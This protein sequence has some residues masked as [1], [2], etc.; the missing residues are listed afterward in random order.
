MSDLDR[1]NSVMLAFSLL[2]LVLFH[3]GR[4]LSGAAAFVL[5]MS[6]KQMAIYYAPAV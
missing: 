6:Y 5:A 2:S 1:Y 3:L 4:D